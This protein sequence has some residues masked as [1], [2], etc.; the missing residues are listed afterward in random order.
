M[1]FRGWIALSSLLNAL[2]NERRNVL[3]DERRSVSL[4]VVDGTMR[5]RESESGNS[6]HGQ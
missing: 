1:V 3:F 5:P 4:L 2:L 6:I